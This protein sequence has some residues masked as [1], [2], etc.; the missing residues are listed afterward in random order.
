M[1]DRQ[2][3]EHFV[4]W[5]LLI[6]AYLLAFSGPKAAMKGY[7][8]TLAA[9]AFFAASMAALRL[10]P[11]IETLEAGEPSAKEFWGVYGSVWGAAS[12]ILLLLS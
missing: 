1:S 7:G 3:I 5:L 6:F 4:S 2:K 10:F 9:C 11:M 8:I 12:G